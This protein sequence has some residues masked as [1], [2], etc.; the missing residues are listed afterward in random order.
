MLS[1][2]Q[3]TARTGAAAIGLVEIVQRGMEMAQ[4]LF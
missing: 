1:L 3:N 2:L 4:K